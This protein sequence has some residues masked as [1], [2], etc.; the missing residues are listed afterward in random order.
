MISKLKEIALTYHNAREQIVTEEATK[1][2]LI[3]PFFAALGFNVFN[4]LEVVPEIIAD[5]GDKKGEKIDYALKSGEEFLMLV[6]CKKCAATLDEKNVSQLFRYFGA[7]RTKLNTRIA[8]LTNGLEY[9]F[10]SDMDN[11]NVLDQIPFFTLDIL[12]LDDQKVAELQ[13]FAKSVFNVESILAKAGEYKRRAG[14]AKLLESYMT[15]PSEAF[16][17]CVLTDIFPGRR[18]QQ[19]VST[20]SGVI[21]DAFNQLIRDRVNGVLKRAINQNVSSGEILAETPVKGGPSEL[22]GEEGVITTPEEIEAHA[23]VKSIVRAI[24]PIERILLR[25]SKGSCSIVLDNFRKPLIK[26][27]FNDVSKKKVVFFND[28]ES[29]TVNKIP[30]ENVFDIYNHSDVILETLNNY[31]NAPPKAPKEEKE[32]KV[33]AVSEETPEE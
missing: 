12:D 17:N 26:L 24:V 6:E 9:Q 29:K 31:L 32:A 30:V 27:F 18:T 16:V 25:D 4:P 33:E 7:L 1:T 11:D 15:N 28:K 21:K 8:I 13:Q 23:I 5:I 19:I 10:F 14:V 20:Y 3:M 22:E 2:A